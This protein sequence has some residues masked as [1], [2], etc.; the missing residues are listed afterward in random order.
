VKASTVGILVL[1][2]VLVL[3]V[4]TFLREMTLDRPTVVGVLCGAGL[5]ALNIVLGYAATSRAL[6]R[7]TAAALR[8]VLGGFF[9]RLVTLVAL[10]FWFHSQDWV[11]EIAFALSFMVFFLVFL[12]IEVRM[13]QRSLNGS[14]RPA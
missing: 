6:R 1:G 3:V 10:L 12:A 14:R 13:V 4:V 5:G 11:N 8:T 9:V 2:A 7:G